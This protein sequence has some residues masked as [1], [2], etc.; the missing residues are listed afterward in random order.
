[1]TNFGQKVKWLN[2]RNL[3]NFYIQTRLL[4][5]LYILARDG[6]I[7]MRTEH[8][9][10]CFLLHD[11]FFIGNVAYQSIKKAKQHHSDI[12]HQ[13]S[14]KQTLKKEPLLLYDIISITQCLYNGGLAESIWSR[15][16]NLLMKTPQKC[17]MPILPSS[18]T[19]PC[20]MFVQMSLT[21][22]QAQAPIHLLWLEHTIRFLQF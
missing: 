2:T 22:V 12:F 16:D 18:C 14:I 4:F 9:I 8:I 7:I 5:Q 3:N 13:N 1:M 20:K 11:I 21:F 15:K 17:I 10:I 6:L 19:K